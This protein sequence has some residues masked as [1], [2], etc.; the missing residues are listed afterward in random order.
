MK[1][2]TLLAFVCLSASQLC[3]LDLTLYINKGEVDQRFEP[4]SLLQ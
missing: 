4:A 3:A 1:I 2:L